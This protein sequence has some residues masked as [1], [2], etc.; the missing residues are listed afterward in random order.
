[1]KSRRPFRLFV[2]N[3]GSVLCVRANRLVVR[4]AAGAVQSSVPLSMIR[5]VTIGGDAGVTVPAMQRLLV[6]GIPVTF[7]APN[8][9]FRGRLEPPNTS[10]AGDRIAQLRGVIDP[11]VRLRFAR[12]IVDGKVHNQAV[13]LGRRMRRAELREADVILA[14]LRHLRYRARTCD[15][16]AE[17]RGVEGRA[18]AV[19]YG[20]I[21]QLLPDDLGFRRRDRAEGDVVNAVTNYASGIIR[22]RVTTEII[23]AG[24]DSM[25]S[26][27]HEPF[28]G[29]PTLAFDLMEEWRAPLIDACALAVLGL[30]AVGPDDVVETVEGPRLCP[31]ARRA[32]ATRVLSRLDERYT[33]TGTHAATFGERITTQIEQF[34]AF[35]R[36]K[37][38]YTPFRWR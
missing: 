19:Y 4:S 1:M 16:L 14:R 32:I 30:R 28:R 17:L 18:A 8:G 33:V 20:A 13:L 29:R 12:S 15:D 38:E 10:A 11:D 31:D 24:L 25:L 5:E 9:L 2:A 3:D 22:S 21:R 6:Q 27:Y 7:L 37:G 35:V 34:R 23:A 36:G 26:L